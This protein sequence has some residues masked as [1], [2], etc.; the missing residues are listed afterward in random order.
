MT[1]L[2]RVKIALKALISLGVAKN[3][4]EVGKLLGYSNKSS[5]SQVINGIVNLP[6]D[7]VDRLCRLNSTLNKDWIK[8]GNG[9][10]LE[11]N[12]DTNQGYNTDNT[13]YNP[14]ESINT[15]YFR[16]HGLSL[17]SPETM[18]DYNTGTKEITEH[19]A[20][21]FLIPTFKGSDYL[22]TVIGS[23]MYPKYNN[24]DIVACKHL[25]L[26]TFFQ[27]NK[28]YVINTEQGILVKRICK[29]DKDDFVT[30]VSDNKDY[31]SFELAKT[32]LLSIA[33]VTGVI[34]LE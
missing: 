30:I 10:V 25:S 20:T 27:W 19:T 14:K 33:I 29:S 12:P 26:N 32:E 16:N 13:Y 2:Q 11:N 15:G 17:I 22:I 34:R 7:F 9:N 5:F 3:Q 8:T 18:I 21:Q 31:D 23:S 6:A 4:E 1:D 24:G 28:V